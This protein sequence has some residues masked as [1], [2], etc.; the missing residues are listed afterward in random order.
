MIPGTI[1]ICVPNLVVVRRSCRKKG[2]YRQTHRQRDTAALYSSI[3][4]R[5]K[6]PSCCCIQYTIDYYHMLLGKVERTIFSSGLPVN[7]FTSLFIFLSSFCL[8]IGGI[9]TVF[10]CNN[11]YT[12]LLPS[13]L[14]RLFG[15]IQQLFWWNFLQ[16]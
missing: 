6:D 5:N 16:S 13:P 3:D 14:G 9:I 1:R 12:F 15:E 2:G 10:S 8:P 7:C 4:N 11:I